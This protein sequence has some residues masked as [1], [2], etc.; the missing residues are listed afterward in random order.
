M[1][2]ITYTAK[3]R[4]PLVSGHTAETA[5]SIDIKLREW[6]ISGDMQK[7]Q[8]VT[9][10]GDVETVLRRS[11]DVYT[12]SLIWDND[13]DDDMRE[14]LYSVAAGETFTLDPFGTV[15]VPDS[16]VTLVMMGQGWQITRM[17]HGETPWRST[18]FTCR[19]G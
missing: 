1:A 7:T 11:A 4:A 15:A 5:Y 17:S 3:S 19:A 6:L 8:H 9:L 14:F 10:S 16:P 12:V 13:D 2:G 18:T